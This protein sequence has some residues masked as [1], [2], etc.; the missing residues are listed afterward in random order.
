MTPHMPPQV[1]RLV[2]IAAYRAGFPRKLRW[3]VEVEVLVEVLV[4]VSRRFQGAQLEEKL[5]SWQAPACTYPCR[6]GRGP[7]LGR[8]PR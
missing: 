2:A 7:A 3:G 4:E 1:E 5:A 6:R 8:R